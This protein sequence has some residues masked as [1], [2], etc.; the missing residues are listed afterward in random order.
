[1]IN[2]SM[3]YNA[4]YSKISPFFESIEVFFIH[5][6]FPESKSEVLEIGSDGLNLSLTSH[7]PVTF[8]HSI[9]IYRSLKIVQD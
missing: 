4:K 2:L 3:Y 1:M 5:Q 6:T 9:A 8:L 7:T